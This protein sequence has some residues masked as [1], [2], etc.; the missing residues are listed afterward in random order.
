MI[1]KKQIKIADKEENEEILN[2]GILRRMFKLLLEEEKG[3][4]QCGEK[5][6]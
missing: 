6:I 4:Y 2:K 5:Y 1:I 3:L